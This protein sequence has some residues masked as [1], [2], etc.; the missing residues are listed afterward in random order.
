MKR[1]FFIIMSPLLAVLMVGSSRAAGD[2]ALETMKCINNQLFGE[3]KAHVILKII[4]DDDVLETKEL[5]MRISAKKE[6]DSVG[7]IVECVAVNVPVGIGEPIFDSL[8]AAI[9]K[10]LFDMPAVKG[11]EFGAGF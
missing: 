7:G 9:A 2:T 6:G 8:D 10:M 1:L 11:V 4:E 3:K 5:A